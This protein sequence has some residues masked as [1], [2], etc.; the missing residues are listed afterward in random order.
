MYKILILSG[1]SFFGTA[2]ASAFAEY[3]NYKG[4]PDCIL[5][6][7]IGNI[8]QILFNQIYN[9]NNVLDT[10]QLGEYIKK[11][12]AK[13][14]VDYYI[15][16]PMRLTPKQI[17]YNLSKKPIFANSIESK[18][19]F[20]N[21][22]LSLNNFGSNLEYIINSSLRIPNILD[23][24]TELVSYEI[25][26]LGNVIRPMF[27]KHNIDTLM[28]VVD[29]TVIYNSSDETLSN[30]SVID[31]LLQSMNS[32]SNELYHIKNFFSKHNVTIIKVPGFYN[33]NI[34]D[35]NYESYQ[36]AGL[37]AFLYALN[38]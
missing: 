19:F 16:S 14:P 26:K 34:I 32:S 30:I 9:E 36:Q 25:Y 2:Q 11:F 10:I 29:I 1:K 12:W 13:E 31:N 38:I 7:N 15:W 18:M 27:V 24:K 6:A 17:F 8:N 35:Y 20:S 5:S 23:A 21:G 4:I 33:T 37:S 28:D 22:V 3:L